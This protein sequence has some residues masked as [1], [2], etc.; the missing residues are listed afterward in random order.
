MTFFFW[1]LAG[2]VS[3]LA[4]VKFGRSSIHPRNFLYS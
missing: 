4:K 2:I 1:Q 3:E